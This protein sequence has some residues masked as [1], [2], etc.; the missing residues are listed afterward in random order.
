MLFETEDRLNGSFLLPQ[1][2]DGQNP[3]T[4]PR[5]P[6]VWGKKISPEKISIF[7]EEG[8][9]RIA[10]KYAKDCQKLAGDRVNTQRSLGAESL[11]DSE[12][13]R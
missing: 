4:H 2:F 10:E 9:Q 8:S 6:C 1:G 11:R 13:E 5:G 12:E 3:R 7:Q